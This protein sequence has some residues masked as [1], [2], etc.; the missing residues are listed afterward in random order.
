MFVSKI[1]RLKTQNKRFYSYQTN[2][3]NPFYKKKFWDKIEKNY[4]LSLF[5]YFTK[6]FAPILVEKVADPAV[7]IYPDL[8]KQ[9]FNFLD[10]GAGHGALIFELIQQNP[11]CIKSIHGIDVSD[12]M[13]SSLKL[14]VH[15]EKRYAQKTMPPFNWDCIDLSVMNAEELNI[16]EGE[17]DVI[18]SNFT[19]MF[20]P[21][22]K[23]ALSEMYRC[24]KPGG[25]SVFSFWGYI[26]EN[27]A[28]HFF[29]NAVT[30]LKGGNFGDDYNVNFILADQ[31]NFKEE[32]KEAGFRD[33]RIVKEKAYF[34]G[35]VE[36]LVQLALNSSLIDNSM[37]PD[38]Q[39]ILE[40][41]AKILLS[42]NKVYTTGNICEAR[43]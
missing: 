40:E 11:N 7:P 8:N 32:M 24:M 1:N 2:A 31:N 43:K 29:Y 17:Y 18:L 23:K 21:N 28:I 30:K 19:I 42:E 10:V 15:Q 41:D 13:I 16:N 4:D 25:I 20:I 12:S 39:K 9:K 34:K 5:G 27:P 14:L 6:K 26:E 3:E 22:R 36:D 35:S 38:F 37:K 33:V